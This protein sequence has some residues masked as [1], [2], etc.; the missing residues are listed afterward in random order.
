[1]AY[2]P[3]VV[4]G[5]SA[6]QGFMSSRSARAA[7]RTQTNR[8]KLRASPEH[9]MDVIKKL[10]PFYRE[11]VASGLGPQFLQE[12]ARQISLAGLT[13][14]GVGE[15]LR[16]VAGAVPTALATGMANE[17]AQ[18]VVQNELASVGGMTAGGTNPLAD[19]LAAGARA[20]IGT[21]E[22]LRSR[23]AQGRNE[24]INRPNTPLPT[25]PFNPPPSGSGG[26]PEPG[27]FPQTTPLER[28]G[29]NI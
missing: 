22:A 25:S 5:I 9:L 14:T 13:G 19:A 23:A 4:A 17:A 29:A 20:Y 11:L 7:A 18:G 8:L 1:M 10:T 28:L 24:L 26:A 16:G 2:A 6:L 3:L 15:A 12:S 27:L 21:S